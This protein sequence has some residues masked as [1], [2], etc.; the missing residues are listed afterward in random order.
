MKPIP[1]RGLEEEV[2]KRLK[3]RAKNNRRSFAAE[4][5]SILL[6]AAADPESEPKVD[7][8][9]ARKMIDEIR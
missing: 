1:V 6:E 9:T 5:K 7:M 8:E 2:V 4:V 3:P